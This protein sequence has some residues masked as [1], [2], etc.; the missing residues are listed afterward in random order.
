MRIALT[1]GAGR[2]GRAIRAR[3]AREHDVVALDRRA[4]PTVELVGDLGNETLLDR[5]CAGADALVH[6]AA[7]HAP[8]VGVLPDS[9]FERIN[10]LGTQRL[11]EAAARH[12]VARI[13]YTSTTALYGTG[14]WIDEDTPPRPRTV[15]HRSKLAAEALLEHAAAAGGPSVRILRMSRCFPEPAPAMA[16]YRLH[17]GVDARDVAE[18]HTLALA[19]DG[20]CCATYVISST[21][22]FEPGDMP[23]LQRDAV[24]VLRRR[25]PGLVAEFARRGWPLPATIDRVYDAARARHAL[26]WAPHHGVASV[27][28]QA[29]AGST[30]VL[31][32]RDDCRE[33][34]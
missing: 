3:L 2:I 20:P 10:V 23:A 12:G 31:P 13:V 14:G 24:P 17:R 15:Y 30:E 1:G 9:E 8:H 22:P 6:V 27:L 25:A 32:A 29:D 7:L 16:A 21:T 26:G 11:I 4:A 18:A 28:A 34:C 19:H 33:P 5:L